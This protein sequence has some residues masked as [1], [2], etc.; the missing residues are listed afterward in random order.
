[1]GPW[2]HSSST[3]MITRVVWTPTSP[4]WQELIV[5]N[6]KAHKELL[7]G[8]MWG[9][10][11]GMEVR[12]N[13][14]SLASLGHLRSEMVRNG[15]KWSEVK[16]HSPKLDDLVNPSV[17]DDLTIWTRHGQWAVPQPGTQPFLFPL[18][19]GSRT[20]CSGVGKY[21]RRAREVCCLAAWIFM[22]VG[23]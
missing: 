20:M 5:A 16:S 9:G 3:G 8:Q 10:F 7:R 12:Q 22:P 14:D 21:S 19:T 4:G 1:M 18:M 11:L 13:M 23:F 6:S 2:H 15:Q 17:A